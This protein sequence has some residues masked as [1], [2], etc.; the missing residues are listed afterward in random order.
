MPVY[1]NFG[2]G[3]HIPVQTIL[4]RTGVPVFETGVTGKVVPSGDWETGGW[5]GGV[6]K[7]EIEGGPL[8]SSNSKIGTSKK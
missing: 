4:A 5:G 3:L 1:R 7:G 6:P 8:T 2:L